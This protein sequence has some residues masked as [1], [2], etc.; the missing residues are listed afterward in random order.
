MPLCREKRVGDD[1]KN[2]KL[3]EN[4]PSLERDRPNSLV[5]Q[6]TEDLKEC[7]YNINECRVKGATR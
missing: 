2:P 5:M 1:G 6:N 4:L 3:L 7:V